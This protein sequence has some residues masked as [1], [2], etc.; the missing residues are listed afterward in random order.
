MA[1]RVIASWK[2]VTQIPNYAEVV[3]E[4]LFRKIFTLAPTV[5]GMF[6][7]SRGYDLLSEEMFRSESF[8]EHASGVIYTVNTAISMLAPDLEPLEEVL[9]ELGRSHRKYGAV[10][11]H[12]AVI[13]Q[14][15]IETLQD[16]MGDTFTPEIK[17]SWICVYELVSATMIAGGA[18]HSP[19]ARSAGRG[20][21][22][23]GGCPYSMGGHDDVSELKNDEDG[24]WEE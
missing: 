19:S 2:L 12:Y 16:A 22:K 5:H 4:L 7:F 1:A 11:E 17:A 14:A 6:R 20:P 9:F 8:R 21:S 3:G 10:P 23:V 15:L 18:S 24:Y 13:G